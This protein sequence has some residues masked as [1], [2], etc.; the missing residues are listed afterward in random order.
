MLAQAHGGR[1]SEQPLGAGPD[2]ES[3][4]LCGAEPGERYDLNFGI[5]ATVRLEQVNRAVIR[6]TLAF[7]AVPILALVL[8]AAVVASTMVLNNLRRSAWKKGL[9]TT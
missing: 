7:L 2:A 4:C 6:G 8:A 5:M 9:S 3:P 1:I